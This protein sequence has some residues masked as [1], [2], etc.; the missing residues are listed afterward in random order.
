MLSFGPVCLSKVPQI[1]NLAGEMH[2]INP[3]S[4]SL[5]NKFYFAFS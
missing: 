1:I 3:V 2:S 5:H 4:I